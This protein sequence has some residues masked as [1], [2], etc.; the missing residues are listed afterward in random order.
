[1]KLKSYTSGV[2]V[3]KGVFPILGLELI[4]LILLCGIMTLSTMAGV[5]GGGVVIPFCMTFFT[6][7]T[8][9][10][11]AMSGFTILTCSI[12]KFVYGLN[13]H[14]P[15]KDAVI[16]D[17]S[18][19]TIMLPV[20]MMGSMIGVLLNIM[21]P[22][23][24]LQTI[25]TIVLLLLTWQSLGKART[26]YK[27]EN[28]K[29]QQIKEK[30]EQMSQS[31]M[32]KKKESDIKM[33][34][35]SQQPI[36][37]VRFKSSVFSGSGRSDRDPSEYYMQD[38]TYRESRI[39][40]LK[41]SLKKKDGSSKFSAY[42]QTSRPRKLHRNHSLSI[43]DKYAYEDQVQKGKLKNQYLDYQ[44][45]NHLSDMQVVHLMDEV[46]SDQNDMSM[47]SFTMTNKVGK[48]YKDGNLKLNLV[49]MGQQN[50]Q[51]KTTQNKQSNFN[52][53]QFQKQTTELTSTQQQQQQQQF[54]Q[55]GYHKFDSFSNFV[56]PN[57]KGSPEIGGAS[58][59][60]PYTQ[61]LLN[62]N[63]NA[64]DSDYFEIQED[65]KLAHNPQEEQLLLKNTQNGVNTEQQ[66]IQK[67]DKEKQ[68]EEN[69]QIVLIQILEKEKTHRQWD[70]HAV[71]FACLIGLVTVN[72]LRGSKKFPSIIGLQKCGILDWTILAL[73]LIMCACICI[74][75][76]RKVVKE[77]GL[78]A[79]YNLGL[80]SSD[81]RFD[82]QAVMNI[83]VFGFI[84]GW[85]S[86]ALGLG[87]GAVFNPVLL[88]MG[89]PPSVSSSTGMYMIMFSTSGSSIVYILYGML[90]YQFAMWLGFWCSIA[91]LV[92]LQMLNKFVKK[93]NRQSPIVFLLGLILGLSALLVPIFAYFDLNKQIQN[94]V[95]IMKFNSMC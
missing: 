41:Q 16:I 40:Q 24:L 26:I 29:L 33:L 79:K 56:N 80:A 19:A 71:C 58:N 32:L 72:L 93:Y 90:N 53:N 52:S 2:C 22:S 20:V 88:S 10:A 87:G 45:I 1:M 7:Q 91:S 70:K 89:V 14:H 69:E 36:M 38:A 63:A 60:M 68:I 95:N 75:S 51:V 55:I 15:E 9:N 78:K 62:K 86:G 67:S 94:G 66:S 43:L 50:N 11:I 61:S 4:G 5:G 34:R 54:T 82:R 35:F 76:V 47:N 31:P 65:P 30:Q 23:L 12:V 42:S 18:L 27:K 21:F 77:Q 57:D 37:N 85:V 81:I 74:F 39:S 64:N 92:G 25:L 13:E 73:F 48:N 8:K 6:F 44:Y 59:H 28:L 46:M 84:G 83:V 17:Y 49:E 3:H